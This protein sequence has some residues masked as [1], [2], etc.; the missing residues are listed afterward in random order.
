MGVGDFFNKAWNWVADTA[1]KVA[2][3]TKDAGQ[4]AWEGA[5]GLATSAADTVAKVGGQVYQDVVKGPI[6][7]VSNAI[8]GVSSLFS[9]PLLWLVGGVAAI[10]IIPPL[11]NKV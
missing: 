7:T 4:D 2:T 9:N 11:L 6:D 3:S 10:A 1:K 8:N 5:K